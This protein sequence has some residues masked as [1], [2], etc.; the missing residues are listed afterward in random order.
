[1]DRGSWEG[2]LHLNM[3]SSLS[4]APR[5]RRRNLGTKVLYIFFWNVL[6]VPKTMKARRLGET[7]DR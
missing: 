6:V 4:S 2:A 5:R 1:L 7:P 3:S